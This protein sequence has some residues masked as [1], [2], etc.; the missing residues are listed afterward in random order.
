MNEMM[1][2]DASGDTRIQWNPRR[3]DEVAAARKRFDELKAKHYTAFKV[4]RAG[5]QGEQMEG[6]DPEEE[7]CIFV[8]R[9][10]GG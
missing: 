3:P 6:F 8:P 9:M 10:V 2:L 7:R 1:V 5:N 4:N